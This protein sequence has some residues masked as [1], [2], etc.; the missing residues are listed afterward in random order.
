VGATRIPVITNPGDDPG[1]NQPRKVRTNSPADLRDGRY[2]DPESMVH[3]P[4]GSATTRKVWFGSGYE[5]DGAEHEFIETR[6]ANGPAPRDR[7]NRSD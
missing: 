3:N 2:R 5:P 6:A 4:G 7:G 1:R